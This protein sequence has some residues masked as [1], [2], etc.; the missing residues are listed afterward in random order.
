MFLKGA[1]A[2]MMKELVLKEIKYLADF[3]IAYIFALLWR[4]N[5]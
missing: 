2:A 4:K 5:R 3:P 1:G